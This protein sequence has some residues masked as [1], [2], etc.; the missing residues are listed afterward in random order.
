MNLQQLL[1]LGLL[2]LDLP[3]DL[4]GSFLHVGV[5]ISRGR[6]F[7]VRYPGPVLQLL[8]VLQLADYPAGNLTENIWF[9]YVKYLVFREKYFNL[10]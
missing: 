5:L 10:L 6:G 1:Q 4:L 9:L 3:L 8:G 7:V 2:G